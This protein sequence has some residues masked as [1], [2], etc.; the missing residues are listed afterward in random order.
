M[1]VGTISSPDHH[2]EYLDDHDDNDHRQ[3]LQPIVG[4][5]NLT[6]M[7]MKIRAIITIPIIIIITGRHQPHDKFHVLT[8]QGKDP[9]SK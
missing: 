2:G 8:Q 7:A 9:S 3:N 4:W 6:V 1:W 5:D